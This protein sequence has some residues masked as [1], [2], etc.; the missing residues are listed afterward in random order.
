MNR[1]LLTTLIGIGVGLTAA[2]AERAAAPG[3][4]REPVFPGPETVEAGEDVQADAPDTGILN[5]D[6]AEQPRLRLR[7]IDDYEYVDPPTDVWRN[8]V[9]QRRLA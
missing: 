5:D 7:I 6:V 1:Q 9:S 4:I 2:A 3:E 8:Q